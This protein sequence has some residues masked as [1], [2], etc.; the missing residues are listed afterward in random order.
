[1]NWTLILRSVLLSSKS[2][3]N[4]INFNFLCVVLVEIKVVKLGESSTSCSKLWNK[5]RSFRRKKKKPSRLETICEDPSESHGAASGSWRVGKLNDALS[6]LLRYAQQ[7]ISNLL[8]PMYVRKNQTIVV[9]SFFIL[10]TSATN[11]IDSK[12]KKR[13]EKSCHFCLPWLWQCVCLSFVYNWFNET[14]G[15]I[16]FLLFHKQ[17]TKESHSQHANR[18][19]DE[20]FSHLFHQAHQADVVDWG[21]FWNLCQF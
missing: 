7:S 4:A 19:R 20:I 16:R 9:S 12:K 18:D 2:R 14:G 11:L 21:K 8:C 13:R 1:M 10:F 6:V 15:S 17:E 5:R 3:V